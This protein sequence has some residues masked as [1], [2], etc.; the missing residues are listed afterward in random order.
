MVVTG[1]EVTVITGQWRRI[2]G[3]IH[4][5]HSE[6]GMGFAV[7]GEESSR[8][9]TGLPVRTDLNMYVFLCALE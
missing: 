1:P 2:G 8:C 9:F 3:S 5:W 4:I 7:C 6:L